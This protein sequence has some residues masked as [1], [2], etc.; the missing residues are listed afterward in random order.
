MTARGRSAIAI[1]AGGALGLAFPPFDLPWPV[2]LASVVAWFVV[3]EHVR[4]FESVWLSWLFMF[5]FQTVLLRWL[6]VVGIDAWLALSAVE[7]LFFTVVGVIR[8]LSRGRALAVPMAAAAWAVMDWARDHAGVLAFG[9]GQ[10]PFAS[11]SAPWVALAPHLPQ[12]AM[13]VWIVAAAGAAARVLHGRRPG[14]VA[15]AG[16]ALLALTTPLAI[17]TPTAASLHGGLRL[18]LVQGGVDRTGIGAIGD[19]RAVMLRHARLTQDELR[20]GGFDLIVWPENAV[21]VDPYSDPVAASSLEAT[22][23]AAGAPILLGALLS[24][25]DGRRNAALLAD[26]NQLRTVYIKQ[27]LVPFGEVL[28]GRALLTR[29]LERTKHIPVDFVPG[30]TSGALVVNGVRLGMVICFEIADEEIPRVAA[31]AGA[32]ALIV[33]TNN[34]TYAGLGQ[35]EQQLRIAQYRALSLGLPVLVVSTNGPSAVIDASGKIV[36]RIDEGRV[37]IIRVSL[38]AARVRA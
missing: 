23:R 17:P 33:Q 10:L 29:Y 19:R 7:A 35:S 8:S 1:A 4:P 20:A 11:T 12:F 37:G 25:P 30:T 2:L 38:P 3:T 21:D 14:R 18:A 16:V 9:W 5:G 28:P 22:S 13:T 36:Q 26:G 27:R 15:A 31:S 6:V 34:A 32:A 24:A